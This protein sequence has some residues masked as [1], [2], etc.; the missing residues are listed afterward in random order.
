MPHK[1]TP[2]AN[3]D[4]RPFWEACN[5]EKFTYQHCK[6]CNENQFYPRVICKNCHSTDLLWKT[7]SG[8][9]SVAAF[10]VV[11]HAPSKAFREDVPYVLAL[12]D[13]EDGI[14]TMM[15]VTHC[16][17]DT[18]YA[19]MPITLHFEKRGDDNQKIPQAKPK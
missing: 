7:A 10:T 8:N 4:T 3:S 5:E 19:G 15:N 1:P 9:G 12:I 13:L 14:R 6:N 17:V 11:H 16:D 2:V 18:V